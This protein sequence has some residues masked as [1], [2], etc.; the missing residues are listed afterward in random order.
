MPDFER[1]AGAHF[2]TTEWGLIRSAVGS[3]SPEAQ[4]ALE[5]LCRSYWRPIYAY[6]RRLGRT[7]QDAEDLT[8][9]FF[10]LLLRR[11]IFAR[12]APG[13][14]RFRTFLLVALKHHLLDQDQRAR[15]LKRGGSFRIVSL[16]DFA[17]EEIVENAVARSGAPD[18]IF[19]RRWAELI[20]ERAL[21]RLAREYERREDLPTFEAL[22]E[23]LRTEPD[24]FA[25]RD[26]G[27]RL[28]IKVETLR[29]AVHRVRKRY[30]IAIREEIAQTVAEDSDI[31]SEMRHLLSA[32]S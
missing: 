31:E 16:D 21:T 15:A 3:T 27:A 10:L 7:S 32:L 22:R 11:E 20:V 6:L 1:T 26:V 19:D 24:E 4:A 14:G 12:V 23:F 8:Q 25:C 13:Q 29:V 17:R 18:A 28:G 30:R 9:E 5:R 2:V